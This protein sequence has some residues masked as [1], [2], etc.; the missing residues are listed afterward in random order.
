MN[1]TVYEYVHGGDVYGADGTADGGAIDFSASINPLGMPENALDAAKRSLGQSVIYP[2]SGSRRLSNAIAAYENADQRRIFC[3]N[4]A[5]DIIFRIAAAIR[6]RK[7]L[8]AAPSFADYERA[9]RALGAEA[10]RYVLSK[11]NGFN[12]G[13]GFV[14]TVRD[15]APGIVFLCNPNNPTGCLAGYG[16]LAEIAAACAETGAVLVVD[17]CFLD[18]V[19]GA[20][21]YTAKPLTEVYKNVVVLKAFT[22]IFA[23]PGLRLGYAICGDEAFV[24]RLRLCGADWPVSN[25]AQA[26]GAAA[27]EGGREHVEK[28]VAYIDAERRRLAAA[29]ADT[30]L[31]VY[32]AR[33]NFIFFHCAWNADLGRELRKNGV[34]IRD[35]AN[36]PGLEPGYYRA[37]VLT[38]EKNAR[39]IESV[40]AARAST[41]LHNC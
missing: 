35:C 19:R 7:I 34:I 10:A 28:S 1:G 26:A 2:D 31:T 8:V 40:K 29:L 39:L 6:P 18:F 4:G 3:S 41:P 16:L 15:E 14:K 13:R 21:Q 38:A 23:M 17:E 22:K 33:A 36:F 32:P 5:S 20:D 27:L 30:G 25:V 24:S 9:G 11:E 37:A 12:I